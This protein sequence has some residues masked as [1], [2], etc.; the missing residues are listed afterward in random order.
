MMTEHVTPAKVYVAVFLALLV[1]TGLT[2]WVAFVN[3]GPLNTVAAL[4]IAVAKMLLVV[5]FFM[6]VRYSSGL[7]RTV[8]VA[9]FFWL[10]ILIALTLSDE[11]TRNWSP[12][13]SGWGPAISSSQN[14]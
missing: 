3:L 7:T 14:P 5:L 8:I 10:A 6:G 12:I 1:L 11:L 9:G 4:A 2:T 13:P